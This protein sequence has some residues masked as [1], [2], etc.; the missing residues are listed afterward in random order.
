LGW[1]NLR[2]YPTFA[3]FIAFFMIF[4][5]IFAFVS[6]SKWWSDNS[7]IDQIIQIG[8]LIVLISVSLFTLLMT[9]GLIFDIKALVSSMSAELASSDF[10]KTFKGFV[11]FGVVLTILI[12][13]T[14][15]G[16]GLLVFSADFRS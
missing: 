4:A 14:A 9:W 3:M 6:V 1:M 16:L 5:P 11:A 15:V 10:G 8:L 12:L 7:G 2:V 13:G